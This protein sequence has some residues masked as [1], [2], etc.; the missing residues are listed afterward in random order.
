MSTVVTFAAVVGFFG[1]AALAGTLS[2]MNLGSVEKLEAEMLALEQEN[3]VLRNK[4]VS[5]EKARQER[6]Q[7]KLHQ[8]KNQTAAAKQSCTG[9]CKKSND[10]V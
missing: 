5:I 4:L 8:A 2:K 6:L 3:F 9:P 10:V 1:G 7:R